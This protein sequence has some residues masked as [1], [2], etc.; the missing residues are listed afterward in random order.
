MPCQLDRKK[1]YASDV[2]DLLRNSSSFNLRHAAHHRAQTHCFGAPTDS[3]THRQEGLTRK[4]LC[5]LADNTRALMSVRGGWEVAVKPSSL[6]STLPFYLL[7]PLI[8]RRAHKIA[9]RDTLS[10]ELQKTVQV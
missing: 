8:A 9:T 1:V 4:A 6:P 5:D 2:P 10:K 3:P 7:T